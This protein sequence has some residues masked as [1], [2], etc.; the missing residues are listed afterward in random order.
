MESTSVKAGYSACILIVQQ[1]TL[2]MQ[3][4][5]TLC[6]ILL[7]DRALYY[8]KYI[9]QTGTFG[10]PFS[11]VFSAFFPLQ[12]SPSV[13]PHVIYNRYVCVSGFK[14]NKRLYV[15][16]VIASVAPASQISQRRDGRGS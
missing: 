6:G 7:H 14:T 5:I 8:P 13:F 15:E 4:C 9:Q 12:F 3:K 1:I 11:K 10:S 16:T 2:I